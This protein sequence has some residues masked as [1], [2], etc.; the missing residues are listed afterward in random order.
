MKGFAVRCLVLVCM[1]IALSSS[2]WA[3]ERPIRILYLDALSGP[4]KD[5]GDRY[6][7]GLQFAI[8]EVNAQGGLLGRK[9]E[10]IAEDSQV[11]PDVAVRKA[12]KYLL[13]EGVD[14]VTAGTGSHVAKALA[15]ATKQ[16]NVLF[17]NLTLSDEATGKDFVYHAV[18]PCYNTAMIARA[19]VTYVA[20]NKPFKRFYLLNQD[21]AYGRDFA[22]AFKKEIKKQIPG[23]EIVG[24]DYHPL[25]G[26][27]LSPFLTK[28]KASNAD[29]IMTAD[30]GPDISILLKQRYELG[31]KA[32]IVNNALANPTVVR[33]NPEA[34]LGNI[35]CDAYMITTKTKE[36]TDL[37]NRWQ[38]RHKGG[39]YPVPDCVSG[40]AY[41]G[42]KFILEGIK[43]A[44][45]VQ[46]NKLVPVLEGMRQ[47]SVNGEVYMRACDHQFQ[48]PLPVVTITS[49]T[50]PYFSAPVMISVSA[51]SIEEQEIDNPRCKRK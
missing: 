45:S 34:A 29:A 39:E 16:Y 14:I 26:K 9:V 46:V 30:Y 24:E 44:Q 40:R 1:V 48:T 2:G 32:V 3:A 15:D 36:N 25:F 22:A 18:R 38:K 8:E 41:M 17:M 5:N 50:A 4:A 13:E 20:Q 33:E 23:A 49:K 28:I 27:D 37:V 35:A 21:Y 12:Q 31:V 7:L 47:Q 51:A 42:M 19:L 10:V 6:L 43:K 11:K